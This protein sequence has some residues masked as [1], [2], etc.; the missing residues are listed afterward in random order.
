MNNFERKV[1]KWI[2]LITCFGLI[3]SGLKIA[4]SD[5][6]TNYRFGLRIDFGNLS[7]P[8]GVAIIFLA[9]YFIYKIMEKYK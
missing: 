7:V 6:Y 9:F 4:V 8:I 2:Y 1:H 5:I 3:Y